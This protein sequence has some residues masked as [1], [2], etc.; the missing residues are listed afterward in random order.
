MRFPPFRKEG[1]EMIHSKVI[2][3]PG[4]IP[5]VFTSQVAAGMEAPSSPKVGQCWSRDGRAHETDTG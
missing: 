3:G 2:M 5:G 4:C 1:G